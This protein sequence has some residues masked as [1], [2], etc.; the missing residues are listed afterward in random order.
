MELQGLNKHEAL[1]ALSERYGC[2]WIE[3]DEQIT[4]PLLLLLRLD[5]EEL[6]KEGWFPRRIENGRADVIASAPSPELA[7]RIKTLLGCEAVDFQVTLPADLY[8]IIEN[9]QDINPGFSPSAGRTPLAR[10]RTY[11][12]GRRSLFAHYR[13]LLAKARTGLAFVRTG[14][15]FITI[16]LL[17]VRILGTGYFLILE[18]P[19][20]VTGTIMLLD[21]LKWYF[22][23]RKIYAGLP[24]CATTEPTGGTSVLEVYNETDTPFFK[25]TGVVPGA[26]E[27]R[28]GWSSLSPVMRRRYLASDRTDFAEERTVLACF[29]TRMAMART[30]L[31]FT[32]SGLAFLSL[33]FGLIRHFHASRWLPFD[34]GLIV[35]GGLMAIE[36]FF[37]Y[38]HGG[39]QAGV[40]GLISVKKKFSM[41]SIWD[42]FFP[43]QHPLPAGTDEQARPLPVKSSYAPG[44]WATTGVALERTVLAERRNVMARLRTVMA[45]ARTGFAFIRTGRS[46]F[47]IGVAFL[48]YFYGSNDIGW[49]IF[50]Y[51]MIV[52]G[53][54][55]MAD[56]FYWALPAERIKSEFPY[57]YCDMEIT[58]PDYGTPGRFWKKAVFSNE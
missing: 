25:R 20:L 13:T 21:G 1:T 10:V 7:Q 2:P 19:L 50:T 28:N 56:G 57:C 45:R 39:R 54:V 52:I 42:S 9:N 51:S 6:K 27:L 31:A 29:R 47:M 22:P 15:A 23:V 18:L 53:L 49:S 46:I 14:F 40:E 30:G 5:L 3:Y 17:F 32:R 44:V 58:I 33:G 11:L 24:V 16:S 34:L 8:R 36:G 43:H 37:W 55:L 41:S 4:A 48:M 26:A 12:A 35:I 38:F